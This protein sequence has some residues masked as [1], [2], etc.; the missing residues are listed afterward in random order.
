SSLISF[1]HCQIVMRTL[2]FIIFLLVT[3]HANLFIDKSV[4]SLAF[5]LFL[6]SCQKEQYQATTK[7]R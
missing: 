4:Y 2:P 5:I 3:L 6:S 1:L 7:Q